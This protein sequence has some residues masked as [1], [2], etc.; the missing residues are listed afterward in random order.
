MA[1]ELFHPLLVHFSI[2]LAIAALGF[3]FYWIAWPQR[4]VSPIPAFKVASILLIAAGLAA[5]VATFFDDAG[6]D[7]TLSRGFSDAQLETCQALDIITVI[8]LPVLAVVRALIWQRRRQDIPACALIAIGMS[9][10]TVA[11][12]SS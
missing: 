3:D 2:V 8:G 7:L 5:I 9:V 4:T 6:F 1:I 11:M 12:V 10:L